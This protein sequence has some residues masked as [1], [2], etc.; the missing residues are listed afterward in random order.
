MFPY[1]IGFVAGPGALII[2][3]N[4]G[5]RV[6]GI[7]LAIEVIVSM[8]SGWWIRNVEGDLNVISITGD[9]SVC[10][11]M[12]TMSPE[13]QLRPHFLDRSMTYLFGYLCLPIVPLGAPPVARPRN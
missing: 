4:I 9:S 11:M 2:V 6:Q 13:S 5:L 3:C 12:L 7:A 10:E 8:R 1:R